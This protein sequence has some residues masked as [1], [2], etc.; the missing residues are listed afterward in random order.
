MP[1]VNGINTQRSAAFDHARD[2]AVTEKFFATSKRAA[3]AAFSR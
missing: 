3:E 2:P 1:A